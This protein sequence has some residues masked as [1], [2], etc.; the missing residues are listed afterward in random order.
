MNQPAQPRA[1]GMTPGRDTGTS[2]SHGSIPQWS[3]HLGAEEELGQKCVLG[4]LDGSPVSP[5]TQVGS[6]G[7]E[8]SGL[9]VCTPPTAPELGPFRTPLCGPQ[10][11]L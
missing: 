6:A 7:Q 9:I 3:S 10:F 11:S 5:E 1:P 2:R 4:K 8:A